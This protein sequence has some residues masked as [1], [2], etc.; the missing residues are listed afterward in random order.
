MDQ[1]KDI[2][3]LS[4]TMEA[5][6]LNEEPVPD[7]TPGQKDTLLVLRLKQ[8]MSNQCFEMAAH[9]QTGKCKRSCSSSEAER[10]LLDYVSEIEKVKTNYFNSTL[11]LHRMQMWHAIAEKLK[12]SDLEANELKEVSDRCMSLCSHIKQLQQESRELQE[13]IS[14]IQTKRLEMK[15]LTHERMKEME[16]LS[17]IEHPDSEKYKATLEKGQSNLEKHKKMVTMTQNILR[18]MLFA[19]KVNWIDDPKLRDIAMTLEEFPIAD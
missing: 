10:D 8:Q 7:N 4:H 6:A 1:P 16:E 14:D 2:G 18:G 19:L 3:R 11:I 9:L 5:V 12:Q 13:E 17:K 15:R